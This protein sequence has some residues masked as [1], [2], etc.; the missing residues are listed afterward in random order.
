MENWLLPLRMKEGLYVHR[1]LG[2]TF[3][4]YIS[5]RFRAS[6]SISH[7]GRFYAPAISAAPEP[8]F[9]HSTE[10]IGDRKPFRALL[11]LNSS[12]L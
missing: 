5:Q 2:K 4:E 3:S 10:Y 11:S 9:F 8:G 7:L 12:I 6:G 1:E